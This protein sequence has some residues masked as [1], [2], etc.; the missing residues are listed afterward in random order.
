MPLPFAFSTDKSEFVFSVRPTLIEALQVARDRYG[1]PSWLLGI[2][3]WFPDGSRME[4]PYGDLVIYDDN[5]DEK[6]WIT[7][8][9]A[10]AL[11]LRLFPPD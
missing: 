8:E 1:F 6:A 7:D 3:A 2:T 10:T 5:G 4:V 9:Q 11:A